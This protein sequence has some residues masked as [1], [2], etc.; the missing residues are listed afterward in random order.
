MSMEDKI[1]DVVAS[2]FDAEEKATEETVVEETKPVETEPVEETPVEDKPV[3]T[4]TETEKTAEEPKEE[5]K[6]EEKPVEESI[7][8]PKQLKG[9]FVK[10]HWESADK[11]TKDE[12]V[13]LSAENER[14]YL[15]AN[16]AE[17]NAK[18]FRKT[19]EPVQGYISEV[20]QASNIPESEV[21][22]NCIDIVQSLNDKPTLTAR[23]MIAGGLIRFEDPVAVINEIAR[24]Y[25]I[26]TKSDMKPRDIPENYYASA[27]QA[28]YEARQAKYVQPE[29][30]DTD[31]QNAIADYVENTPGI[32]A[33][34]DD[35]ALSDK[36]IRQIQMERQ[37]DPNSS[38]ITIINR[39]AEL[40]EHMVKTPK[41]TEPAPVIENIAEK[42]MAKVVAPKASNP[43][44]NE[45]ID[46]I[47]EFTPENM[48][49]QSQKYAE[50]SVKDA[51]RAMGL[52][53]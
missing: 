53:D 19:I 44:N 38:D 26:D 40:F 8:A 47:E 9:D 29:Q 45:E 33:L 37:A 5:E 20:A 21:I 42:K 32:K 7:A 4:E 39:A 22:R 28:K 50:R 6:T 48:N 51:L 14:N 30:V 23:Q 2:A 36:F 35:P 18:M 41:A 25:G 16:E 31:V 49:K 13:R 1:S 27:A 43:S 34:V 12:F 17:H 24:T 15:R 10:S 11:E 52:D 46:K 3:E